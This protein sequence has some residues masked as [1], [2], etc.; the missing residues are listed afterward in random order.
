MHEPHSFRAEI[1]Q[2]LR[3]RF[4]P[5]LREDAEHLI[6]DAGRIG[7]RAEEIE[8]RS[9][10]ELR[11]DRRR[12]AHRRGDA[13]RAAMKPMPASLMQASTSRGARSKPTPSA[14]KTSLAPDFDEAARLPCLATGTP[15][16]A[17][18]SAASVEILSV[19]CP[20]P[21]VPT[22]SI[23]PAGATTRSI[24]S[25]IATTAPVI[26]ATVSPRARSAIRKPPSWAGVT[27]SRE[28]QLEGGLRLG[29]GQARSRSRPWR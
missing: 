27:L 1:A 13:S 10:A 9:G 20:S 14:D 19:P 7:E 11:P 4:E 6:F 16:A 18:I 22:M 21:P 24:L 29:L 17:T 25:R 2:H 5:A 8:N 26:S 28:N 3:E 23:A 12:M 15:Q